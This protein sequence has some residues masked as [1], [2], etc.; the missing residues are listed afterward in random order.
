MRALRISGASKVAAGIT[1][2]DEVMKVA[3]PAEQQDA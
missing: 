1:T 2:L 3:P